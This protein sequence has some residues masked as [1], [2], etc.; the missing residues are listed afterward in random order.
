[1]E[2]GGSPAPPGRPTPRPAASGDGR[3]RKAEIKPAKPP[4]RDKRFEQLLADDPVWREIKFSREKS[5]PN[6]PVNDD[7]RAAL[8]TRAELRTVDYGTKFWKILQHGD[9]EDLYSL[10]R[11]DGGLVP[12]WFPDLDECRRCT[13]GAAWA[14]SKYGY[15]QLKQPALICFNQGALPG[16]TRCRRGRVPGEVAGQ[17]HGP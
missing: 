4:S 16:K 5:G 3:S 12:P 6:R 7:E 17:H 10:E 8:G 13:I 2:A 1:M 15:E 9:S 11:L 14:G